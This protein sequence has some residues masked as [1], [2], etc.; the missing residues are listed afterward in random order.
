MTYPNTPFNNLRLE[1][2]L[3]SKDILDYELCDVHPVLDSEGRA[4]G[5]NNLRITFPSGQILEL[6]SKSEVDRWINISGIE[7]KLND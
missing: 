1:E 5:F 2:L 3:K 7:I 6:K 4:T